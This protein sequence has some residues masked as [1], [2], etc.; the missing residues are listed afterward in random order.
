MAFFNAYA[1]G[2]CCASVCTNCDIEAA[3]ERL[4]LDHPTGVGP[5]KLS[6]DKTFSGGEPMPCECPGG[7]NRKHYL[8][9]C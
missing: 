2:V 6:G 3:T 1:M 7:D 9:E 5:W 8:F 4:N